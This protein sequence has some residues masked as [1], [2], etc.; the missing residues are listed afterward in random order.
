MVSQSDW[1]PMMMAIG[2]ASAVVTA[3]MYGP[4]PEKKARIIGIRPP[5]ARE[6]REP[7]HREP[8]GK[9]RREQ[10]WRE[11]F[12]LNTA[13]T[14]PRQSVARRPVPLAPRM[15]RRSDGFGAL[16]FLSAL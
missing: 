10:A 5:A 12:M 9:Q 11:A 6:N 13:F 2:R 14:T 16:I 1:L 3:D 15:L 4:S 7:V 8:G